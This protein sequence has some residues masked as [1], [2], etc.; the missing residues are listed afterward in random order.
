MRK[1]QKY[2]FCDKRQT[3]Q[4]NENKKL[5]IQFPMKYCA[6]AG[7]NHPLST[8]ELSQVKKICSDDKNNF[9]TETTSGNIQIKT[10][11]GL[12]VRIKFLQ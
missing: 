6:R 12:S 2:V 5:H 4:V 11:S 7:A 3:S 10:H 1:L 9:G 8:Y